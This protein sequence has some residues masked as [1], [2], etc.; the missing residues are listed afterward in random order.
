MNLRQVCLTSAFMFSFTGVLMSQDAQTILARVDS[1]MNAPRDMVALGEMTLIDKGGSQKVRST[2]IYQKGT[3]WRLVRFLTPADVHGVSFLR[4]PDDRMYLYLPAFRK[5]RRIASSIKYEKF[6]GTDFS[7]EDLSPSGYSQNYGASLA[8]SDGEDLYA[9][10]LTPKPG[11]DVSYG[12][13]VL[14]IRKDN[15]VSTKVEYYNRMGKLEKV[16]S[17]D[18]IERIGPYW[19]G[20]KMEMVDRRNNHRTLFTLS[21]IAFDQNLKDSIF[22]VRNLKRIE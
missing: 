12:K 6:M 5:V 22:T 9:L 15:Y 3:E 17:V 11:A 10:V 7:Y 21:R 8:P 19:V 20:K 1:V 16:L 18:D 4:L 2:K 13:L 14:K